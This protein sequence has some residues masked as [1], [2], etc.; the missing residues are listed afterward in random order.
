VR[1]LFDFA[2]Q[3]G[4]AEAL[5]NALRRVTIASIGEVTNR[6]LAAR[7]LTPKIVPA[8]SKMGALAQSVAD[9]FAQT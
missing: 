7:N 8:Q 9:Y 1:M 6:A 4:A 3:A 2:A 5:E